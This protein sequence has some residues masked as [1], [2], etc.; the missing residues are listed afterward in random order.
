MLPSPAKNQPKSQSMF[1]KNNSPHDLYIYN[2]FGAE[3][4]SDMRQ[5]FIQP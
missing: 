1:H 5:F 2:N 3:M 4:H